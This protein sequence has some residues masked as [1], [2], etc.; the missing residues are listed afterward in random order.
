MSQVTNTS[1]FS[2]AERKKAW[3][4]LYLKEGKRYGDQASAFCRIMIPYIHTYAPRSICELGCGYGRDMLF[5]DQTL[6]E[7]GIR[8][9]I[10][11]VDTSPEAYRIFVSERG[12][13]PD[14][15]IDFSVSD[16][17]QPATAESERYDCVYSHFFIHLFYWK[18][19][20]NLFECANQ[21]VSSK[22]F[23]INSCIS[24]ADKKCGTGINLEDNCYG[25]YPE[26]PWHFIHFWNEEEIYRLYSSYGFEILH[27]FEYIEHEMILERKEE[28]RAW[29]VL[30]MKR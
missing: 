2:M 18:E 11:G 13:L 27:T 7:R 4:A 15:S 6:R 8:A 5:L 29:F 21:K 3:D 10:T 28:S 20:R 24:T 19:I 17:L 30:S 1:R 12:A 22:G 14:E 16:C 9:R 25:C 23:F 26:R